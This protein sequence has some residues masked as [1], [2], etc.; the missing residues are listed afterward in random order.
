MRPILEALRARGT[1][2]VICSNSNEIWWP[3]QVQKLELKS[4]FTEERTI[5]SSRIGAPKDSDGLEM[6]QAA[7]AAAGVPPARCFFVD[8]RKPNVVRAR[9]Y[10]I[11]A[12]LFRGPEHL[13]GE[14]RKRR[15]L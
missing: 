8:D 14:L 15:L 6:F 11:D 4:F 5:L 7:V 1:P 3:R 9:R 12:M 10:G 2:L 13:A